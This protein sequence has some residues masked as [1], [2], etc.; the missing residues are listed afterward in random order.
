M[1]PSEAV[2]AIF[3]ATL[4]W[5]TCFPDS[6]TFADMVP[7]AP[8]SKSW[9]PIPAPGSSLTST[10]P[11]S[12]ASTSSTPAHT[13]KPYVSDPNQ[14]VVGHIDTLW[15]VLRRDPDA[16]ASPWSSLLPL[17]DPYIVPGGRFDEIYY[18][19]SYFIMLGLEQSGRHDL[20]VDELK[21]FATLINRYG[22][23]P[24][25]N[26]T[27]YLSRSQPPFFAQMVALVAAE[28]WR[29]DLPAISARAATG[30]HVLDGRQR[31]AGGGSCV[32]ASGAALPT[33]PC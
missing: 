4:N 13:V 27:Y 5:R 9:L 20:V 14:D 21:N 15:D 8:P 23:I 18:W 31:P 3:T 11:R 32:P 26:R 7:N 33:A 12:S 16:S 29:A 28:G 22:H 2:S 24:N 25:G 10:S 19:D 17:P 6:K 1:P 30:I